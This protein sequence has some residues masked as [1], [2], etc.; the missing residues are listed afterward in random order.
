MSAI[1]CEPLTRK[2]RVRIW[3]VTHRLTYAM[4]GEAICEKGNTVAHWLKSPTMPVL[5]R[6][7]LERLGFP[8]ELLPLGVNRPRGGNRRPVQVIALPPAAADA[9][10]RSMAAAN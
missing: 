10:P 2:E 7:R 9:E 3:M 1:T 8:P 5:P 6:K 4:L